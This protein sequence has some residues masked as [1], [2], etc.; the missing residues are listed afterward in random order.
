MP[1]LRMRMVRNAANVIHPV[2]LGHLVGS[3]EMQLLSLS[4]SSLGL[5]RGVYWGFAGKLLE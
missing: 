2:L 1:F 5:L 3:L 4:P